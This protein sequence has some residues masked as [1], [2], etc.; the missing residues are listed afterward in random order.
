MDSLENFRK[1]IDEIDENLINLLATR[2]S[3]CEKVAVYKKAHNIPMMQPERISMIIERSMKLG[4][5]YNI[6]EE[7]IKEIFTVIINYSCII[8]DNIIEELCKKYD[9]SI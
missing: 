3:I 1:E 8:E 2:C 5:N 6:P 7:F 9:M 4:K